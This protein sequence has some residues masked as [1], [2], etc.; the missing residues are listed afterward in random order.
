MRRSDQEVC[1]IRE[2][3]PHLAVIELF[4]DHDMATEAL[5]DSAI[6]E[7]L[8]QGKSVLVDISAC[9]FVDSSLVNVIVRAQS[10]LNGSSG[11][12]PI[13][14]VCPYP[15]LRKVFDLADTV[16]PVVYREMGDAL[17]A[18]SSRTQQAG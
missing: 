17:D 4:G 5:V 15:A 12:A 14:V 10:T 16:A 18:A 1:V 3:S 9:S 8:E 6:S 13:A 2:V 11:A 7:Q